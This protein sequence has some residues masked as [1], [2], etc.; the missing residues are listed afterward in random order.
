MEMEDAAAGPG[1]HTKL[2]ID[3]VKSGRLLERL[4]TR[5]LGVVI[6]LTVTGLVAALYVGMKTTCERSPLGASV[7]T[8]CATSASHPYIGQAVVLGIGVLLVGVAVAALL[9]MTVVV[10]KYCSFMAYGE[11]SDWIRDSG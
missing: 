1:G 4:G 2:R 8:S 9:Q 3:L 6:V 5:L 7:G 10:G 11:R